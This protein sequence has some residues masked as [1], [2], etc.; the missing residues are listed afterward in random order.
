MIHCVTA[1]QFVPL[2]EAPA[3][4]PVKAVRCTRIFSHSWKP[5]LAA[6]EEGPRVLEPCVP[7]KSNVPH[8]FFPNLVTQIS[9]S[10]VGQLGGLK[11]SLP[12]S[13]IYYIWRI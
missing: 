1:L 12:P 7:D 5:I 4:H 6:G 9:Q 13:A 10:Y 8:R 3:A 11:S 2:S